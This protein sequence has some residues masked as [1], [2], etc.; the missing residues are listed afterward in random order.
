M[1]AGLP[2]VGWRAGNLPDLA[3]HEREALIVEPGDITGLSPALERL[4]KDEELRARVGEAAGHRAQGLP[5][6]DDSARSLFAALRRF[7]CGTVT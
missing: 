4:S 6:W 1:A 3:E 7:Q 2:V 5:T